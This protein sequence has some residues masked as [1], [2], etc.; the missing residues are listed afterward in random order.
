[1]PQF[2][3]MKNRD[4]SIIH[5]CYGV[6]LNINWNNGCIMLSSVSDISTCS[7]NDSYYYI[8][9]SWRRWFENLRANS[10]CIWNVLVSERGC[11]VWCESCEYQ[12]G[13]IISECQLS[14][15]V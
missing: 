10:V 2:I 9:F 7:V 8:P 11:H 3:Y 14:L 5:L 4:N 13:V 15:G 6:A 12:V 1:M